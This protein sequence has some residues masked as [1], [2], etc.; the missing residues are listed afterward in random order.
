MFKSNKKHE[1]KELFGVKNILPENLQ[2]MYN[3]SWSKSFYENVFTKINEDVFSV[4]F[5]QKYS[6]PNTPVNIYVSLEI[7]KEN[8]GL[9]DE[10]L[11]ERFHFDNMFLLALGINNIGDMTISQRAFYYMRSRVVEYDEENKTSL[12]NM[13]LKDINEDYYKKFGISSK[14]KR[15]DSTLIGSNIRRLNRIKLF[16]E[17]IRL[18]LEE[19]SES[20][21]NLLSDE[22]KTFKDIAV[23]NYVYKLGKQET[24][25]KETEIALDLY[26]IEML[27]KDD[28]SINCLESYKKIE[29][30]VSEQ[31]KIDENGNIEM[32]DKTEIKSDSLQSPHDTDATYRDKGE[33]AKQGFSITGVETCE[34]KNVIQLIDDVIVDK[35]N[36]DDSIILEENF[37]NI[38]SNGTDELIVD[39]AYMN[40][41][42][43]EKSEEK[44]INIIT[45]AIRGKKPDDDKLSSCDFVIEDDKIISCPMGKTPV[46][47]ENQDDKIVAC[48]SNSDCKNCQLNCPIR[49]NKK[50]DNVLEFHKSKIFIDK[51]RQKFGNKEY[52][53]KCRLRPAIE[54]TMFQLKLHLRN[55]KS[56]FRGLVKNR[57]RA[58]IRAI[59]INFRRVYA[60]MTQYSFFYLFILKV[61]IYRKNITL[62]FKNCYF[63]R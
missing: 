15:I 38:T 34:E 56:R 26:K 19:L 6:R 39:G 1:C 23:E 53:E 41:N 10:D 4:L 2:K 50:K 20:K 55:G 21:L 54:G 8:F 48:F 27:F 5:S 35:N 61:S 31:L 24:R 44:G 17:V 47:T 32:K 40:K 7:L 33:Q 9:S 51:Q 37:D 52:L 60:Y 36:K 13:I 3:G 11:L 25:K 28:D 49:K 30:V 43:A 46:K 58:N 57:M 62:F 14:I 29:R 63:F 18:F 42:V 22:I 16:L 59:S 45:T 12:F